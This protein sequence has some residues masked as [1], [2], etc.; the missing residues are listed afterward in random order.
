MEPH[1]LLFI[2][3]PYF[4]IIKIEKSQDDSTA[5]NSN[6][7]DPSLVS[8]CEFA[9][10]PGQF[11]SQPQLQTPRHPSGYEITAFPPANTDWQS[12]PGFVDQ[13]SSPTPPS[14]TSVTICGEA[15]SSK[16][17]GLEPVVG[18]EEE[19][20]LLVPGLGDGLEDWVLQGV[21]GAFFSSLVQE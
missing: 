7:I 1:G 20:H 4:G 14:Q 16:V 18:L 11:D 17:M 21:D 6:H 2:R 13:L 5:A 12:L 19:D 3:I 9:V 15:Q 8:R 10:Q